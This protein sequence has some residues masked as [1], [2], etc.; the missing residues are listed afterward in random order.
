MAFWE[1]KKKERE[2][3]YIRKHNRS[4]VSSQIF[5]FVILLKK[6]FGPQIITDNKIP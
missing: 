4:Y 2:R 3:E 1:G 6:L 5:R